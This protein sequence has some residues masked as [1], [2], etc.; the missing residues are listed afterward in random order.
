MKV[1]IDKSL[2][3]LIEKT[4]HIKPFPHI[5]I[6]GPSGI[7]KTTIAKYITNSV[8]Q[9]S[10][11]IYPSTIDN[12]FLLFTLTNLPEN[13]TLIIDEI[14]SLKKNQMETL[15]QPMEEGE[16]SGHKIKFT[17]IGTTTELY[18][19]PEPLFRRFRIIKI[20]DYYT[21]DSMKE[22]A[23]E[24]LRKPADGV[25]LDNIVKMSK[26]RPGYLRNYCEI[27]SNISGENINI[28]DLEKL[29]EIVEVDDLGLSKQDL[30][31]LIFLEKYKIL[32]LTSLASLLQEKEKTVE[33]KIEPYLMRLGFVIKTKKGR[34]ITNNGI[35][36]LY[37]LN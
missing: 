31:Y 6:S 33:E 22:I 15:Y 4:K 17:L 36:H 29:K 13:S 30:K 7:G 34:V 10:M 32:S 24:L 2:Q 5:L 8:S 11:N 37:T 26:G 23:S 14:H 18:K 28:N 35:M 27:L 3:E 25:V 19:I 1:I 21:P 12:F 16:I 9:K 20:I